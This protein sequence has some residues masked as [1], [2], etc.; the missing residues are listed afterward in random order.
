[1][2]F[3]VSSAQKKGDLGWNVFCLV[4]TLKIYYSVS[5]NEPLDGK[6]LG[7]SRLNP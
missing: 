7:V 4:K 3:F 6:V 1:M 2:S 5:R